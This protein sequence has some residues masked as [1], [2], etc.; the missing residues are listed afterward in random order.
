M[1]KIG[2]NGIFRFFCK[3]SFCECN[4]ASNEQGCR[5]SLPGKSA[6]QVC[7]ASLPG[8]S[9]GQV[10]RASLPGKSAGQVC[11]ASLPGKS[12]RASLPGKSAGQVCR[13]SLPGKSAG[14]VCRA[15]LPGK[16]AGQ[17]HKIGNSET[18]FSGLKKT[19]RRHY[20]LLHYVF[21]AGTNSTLI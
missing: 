5:A 12:C 15:S 9:A 17:G 2:K 13:A 16:S 20:Q 4:R 6:G 11:R 21:I 18:K 19:P 8:K 14:Q 10:C 1:A 7:R 3:I